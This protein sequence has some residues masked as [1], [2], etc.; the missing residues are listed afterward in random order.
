M[1]SEMRNFPAGGLDVGGSFSH[2][3]LLIG[4]RPNELG[5]MYCWHSGVRR[6]SI[7]SRFND[8]SVVMNA[9]AVSVSV[10]VSALIE[11]MTSYFN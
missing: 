2:S 7:A 6:E 10:L 5:Q 3:S 1:I 11:S 8:A 9:L 4:F